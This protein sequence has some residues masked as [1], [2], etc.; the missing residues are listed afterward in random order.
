MKHITLDTKQAKKLIELMDRGLAYTDE[1]YHENAYKPQQKIF[2]IKMRQL[3]EQG[4]FK[5]YFIYD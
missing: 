1:H 4:M 5:N 2:N 3:K